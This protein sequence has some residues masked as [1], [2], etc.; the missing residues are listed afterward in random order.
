VLVGTE[1]VRSLVPAAHNRVADIRLDAPLDSAIA[2]SVENSVAPGPVAI[3]VRPPASFGPAGG[4][5]VVDYWGMAFILLARGWQPG[6]TSGFFGVATH[7]SVPPGSRWPLV[8]VTVH[9]SDKAITGVTVV[10]AV[11]A[12]TSGA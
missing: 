8:T 3:R 2:R 11:K 4:G 9:P 6:L 7:L 5:Y 12:T 1:G 10:P